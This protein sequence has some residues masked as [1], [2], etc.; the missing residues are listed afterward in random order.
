[1]T[2][3][4]S[5]TQLQNAAADAQLL[6][7]VING[8]VSQTFTTR[9]GRNVKSLAKT[10]ADMG[11][12]VLPAAVTENS[13]RLDSIE[14]VNP[15]INIYVSS[16]GNDS[17][18]GDSAA[19]SVR[20]WQQVLDLMKGGVTNNIWVIGDLLIDY[21]KLLTSPPSKLTIR[22]VAGQT[23]RMIA[24]NHSNVAS[25]TG[26]WFGGSGCN[27]FCTV[28]IYLDSTSPYGMFSTD[29]VGS[30]DVYYAG[31]AVTQSSG[32]T[33]HLFAT[34]NGGTLNTIMAGSPIIG[35]EGRV[36]R[37]VAAGANPNDNKYYISNLTAG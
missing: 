23:A 2:D 12:L 32:N 36:Y 27:V 7:D 14:S 33:S 25:Y 1:M 37:D 30:V 35:V 17:A 29:V 4:V 9:L 31:G 8:S 20:T 11:T 6:E 21:Y 10:L 26:I 34:I 13:S 28:P 24:R 3:P 22:P 19:N 18:T 15:G 5:T 16:S